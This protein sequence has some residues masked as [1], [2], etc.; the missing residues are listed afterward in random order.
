M[1]QMARSLPS[2]GLLTAL[3]PRTSSVARVMLPIMGGY[4]MTGPEKSDVPNVL[5]VFHSYLVALS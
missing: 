5:G 2:P 4:F 1:A 3:S